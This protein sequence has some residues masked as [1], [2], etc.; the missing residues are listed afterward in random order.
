[1][2]HIDRVRI[3]FG[4]YR[5]T[6]KS[7]ERVARL[8]MEHLQ[9]MAGPEMEQRKGPRAVDRARIEPVRLSSAEMNDEMVARAVA[10][11]CLAMLEEI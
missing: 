3:S 4:N 2:I 9:E 10:R 5:G 8:A 11:R 1:M 6:A 7:A